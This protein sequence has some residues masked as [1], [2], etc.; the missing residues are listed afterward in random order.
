MGGL[1]SGR[2]SHR[3]NRNQVIRNTSINAKDENGALDPQ[4]EKGWSILSLL[5]LLAQKRGFILWFTLAAAVLTSCITL[6]LPLRYTAATSVLPPQQSTSGTAFLSQLASSGGGLAALAG[7]SLG[8]NS[9]LDMYVAMFRSRTVEDA[10][11]K[12]FDLIR[13][14]D[15]KRLSDARKVFEKRSTAVAGLKDGVIRVTVEGST[16]DQAATMANAYVAEFQKLASGVATTEA[17]QRRL[18]FDRQLEEAK[19]N[20]S[21]AEQDLKETELKTGMVQPDSQS[22]AMIESAATLQAQISAKEVQLQ[23]ISSFAT[24]TNPDMIVLK[25]QIAELR[26]QLGQLTGNSVNE[27]D[28]FVPKG[29]VPA[30]ALDYVRKFRNVKYREVIF[31]ALANQ[32]QLA[33][34]DEAKQGA[35]FQVIDSAV[36]PDRRSYP[37]RTILVL[38]FTLLAFI[39]ACFI[40][41]CGGAL[42][43]LRS[44]PEDGPKLSALFAALRSRP[45]TQKTNGN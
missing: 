31:Q 20:L 17:G 39:F 36:P 2:F 18:F 3:W 22:R 43:A 13:I 10:M 32:Y 16:P 41:W 45:F 30:A 37:Q 7:S 24:D 42:E 44:D 40:A 6:L 29:K 14:Y 34:L 38:L 26:T 12:R 21:K 11:I 33:R 25:K 1:H 8:A 23:T 4:P 9:Q 27:S 19:D 5:L 15:V 35:V 28:V